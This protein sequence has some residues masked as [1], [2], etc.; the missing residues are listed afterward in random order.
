MRTDEKKSGIETPTEEFRRLFGVTEE[1][2]KKDKAIRE[3]ANAKFKKDWEAGVYYEPLL[4]RAR[5]IVEERTG[6]RTGPEVL[7]ELSRLK[8][9]EKDQA[10]TNGSPTEKGSKKSESQEPGPTKKD[11]DLGTLYVRRYLEDHGRKVVKE[12]E[13]GDSILYCLEECIFDSNHHGNESA[14]G[15]KSDGLLFYKC[16]HDSCDGRTWKEARQIISGDKP[17]LEYY[18]GYDPSLDKKEGKRR[19]PDPGKPYLTKNEKGRV[20]F[21]PAIMAAELVKYFAPVVH[22]GVAFGGAMYKYD[23]VGVWRL[24]PEDEVKQYITKELGDDAKTPWKNDT[25]S[26]FGDNIYSPPESIE[27]NPY[28]INLKNG[29]LKIPEMEL[30]PHDPKYH[31]RNQLPITYDVDATCP[32]WEKTLEEIFVDDK[33]RISVV[34]QFFGY[35]F[36]PRILFPAV[37]FLIG[38]GRNG[39]GVITDVLTDLIGEH[40]IC[41]ISLKQMEMPFGIAEIKDRLLNAVAE[42]SVR[43]HDTAM[44]KAV[45]AGDRVQAQQK[46]KSDVKFRPFAK[47]LVSMN[48]FPSISDKTDAFFRRITILELK[49]EFEGENDRKGLAEEIYAERDGVFIWALEGLKTTL[50]LKRFE[51]SETV[52]QAKRRFR[53]RQNP[54]LTFVEELCTVAE[55]RYVSKPELYKE[56]KNWCED[57]A[58]K[59]ILSKPGF[60]E[61]ILTDFKKVTIK[62]KGSKECFQGIGLQADDNIPF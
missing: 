54:A 58:I 21:N 57:S 26:L 9:E 37:L 52:D 12:K 23:Q 19:T 51:V 15:Q 22:E 4:E 29:M 44:F 39:K 5:D 40:N 45:S 42:T 7:V 47:H 10:E 6:K 50:E 46:F 28:L 30:V 53:V 2:I 14:I 3:R 36:F 17:L 60:Y 48:Q 34:K 43:A 35:S 32:L 38:G 41:H 25:F 13:V 31:S 62:R 59:Q 27:T 11:G 49:Q 20:K 33:T 24:L 55:E 56:Y 1:S 8:K 61:R 16:F 18:S